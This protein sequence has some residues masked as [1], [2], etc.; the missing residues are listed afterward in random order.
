[1]PF[2]AIIDGPVPK[3]SVTV[4][5]GTCACAASLTFAVFLVMVGDNYLN[6]ES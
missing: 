1:M 2:F 6:S 3:N 4:T 5:R